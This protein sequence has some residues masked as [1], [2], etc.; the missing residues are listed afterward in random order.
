MPTVSNQN[1]IV[2]LPEVGRI[3]RGQSNSI[4]IVLHQD[5]IGNHLNIG[6][7]NEVKV[8][9]YNSSNVLVTTFSKTAGNLTYGAPNSDLQ[10]EISLPLT[11]DQTAALPFTDAGNSGVLKAKV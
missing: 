11:G 3:V 10:G 9:L 4:K 2:V 6:V 7:A 1:I 5:Y 8:E